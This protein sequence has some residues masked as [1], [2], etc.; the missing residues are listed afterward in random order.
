MW[1]ELPPYFEVSKKDKL[2]KV[3]NYF[4]LYPLKGIKSLDYN[5]FKEVYLLI[6]DKK[7]LTDAPREKMD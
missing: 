2:T 7:H 3:I 4:D 5:C 1:I 6:C